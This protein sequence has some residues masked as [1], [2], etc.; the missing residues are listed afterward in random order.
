LD[1]GEVLAQ[2]EFRTWSSELPIAKTIVLD[3][4]TFNGH[5]TIRESGSPDG[6]IKYT[7]KEGFV[8]RNDRGGP[9]IELSKV[10]YVIL[11]GLTLRGG[12]KDVIS[13][14]RCEQVRIVNCDIAGWG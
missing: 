5:L 10:K 14:R 9:L 11:E 6:W 7:S 4:E 2:K 3:E 13:V 8:L 12:L 1:Q